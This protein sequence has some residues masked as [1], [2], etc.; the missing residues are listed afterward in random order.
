[1]VH[2]DQTLHGEFVCLGMKVLYFSL[3]FRLNTLSLFTIIQFVQ[4]IKL[5]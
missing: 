4:R 3:L 1:M 5:S 2:C